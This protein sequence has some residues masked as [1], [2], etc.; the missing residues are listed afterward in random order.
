[1]GKIIRHRKSY[2]YWYHKNV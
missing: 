1:M 2:Y